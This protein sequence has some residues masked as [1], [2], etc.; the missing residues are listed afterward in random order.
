M[1][2]NTPISM[3]WDFPSGPVIKTSPF[4]VRCEGSMPGQQAKISYASRPKNQNIKQK[5]Y[6]K[7]QQKKNSIKALKMVH[8]KKKILK[9]RV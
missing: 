1:W 3:E 9:E 7:K 8:I 6:C 2:Q 5:L 4:N